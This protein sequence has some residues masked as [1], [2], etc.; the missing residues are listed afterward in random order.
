[1]GKI[2]RLPGHSHGTYNMYQMKGLVFLVI[3]D[4]NISLLSE[5]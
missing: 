4:I 1:M 5:N 2:M 3:L